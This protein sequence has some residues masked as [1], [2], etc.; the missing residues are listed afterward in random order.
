M[1]LAFVVGAAASGFAAAGLT[2]VLV[3][4][5]TVVSGSADSWAIA[6][7]LIAGVALLVAVAT[8][9]AEGIAY[10]RSLARARSDGEPWAYRS[11]S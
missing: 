4:S 9:V 8:Y 5:G 6:P 2:A 11:D 3:W 1:I 7:W 10:R